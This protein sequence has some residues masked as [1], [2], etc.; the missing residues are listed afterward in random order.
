MRKDDGNALPLFWEKLRIIATVLATILI[1]IVIAVVSQSYTSA[2]KQNEIGVRYVELA[3]GI[4]RVPPEESPERLR[5]WAIDVVNSYSEVPLP[6]GALLELKE[7]QLNVFLRVMHD[8]A[9]VSIKDIRETEGGDNQ[10]DD[11]IIDNKEDA[12]TREGGRT[13]RDTYRGSVID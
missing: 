11:R 10:K 2:L 7:Y 13:L 9:S 1:P 5:A 12:E 8:M 4:L 6:E 3:I